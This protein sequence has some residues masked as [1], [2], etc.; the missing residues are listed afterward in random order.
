M[1]SHE[2]KL[3]NRPIIMSRGFVYMKDSTE[4]IREAERIV[5]GKLNAELKGKTTFASIKNIVRDS[6]TSYFHQKTRRHP[7]IIPVIMNKKV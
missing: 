6:L 1:D 5:Q 3:L 7:M 2:G 4:M